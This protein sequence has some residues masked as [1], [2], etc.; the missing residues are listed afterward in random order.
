MSSIL[1]IEDDEAVRILYKRLFALEHYDIHVA[2]DGTEGLRLARE[3]KPNLIL[4]D[5]LMPDMDGVDVLQ[6][7]KSD[8]ETKNCIVLMMTNIGEESI[9]AESIGLGAAGYIVK[10][11]C[12][13]EQLLQEVATKIG[14][15]P[16]NPLQ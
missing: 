6:K 12:S 8:P 4:L 13:P 10:A 3:V 15:V 1:V 14:T 9:I 2:A 16:G 7:L 11:H 5:I